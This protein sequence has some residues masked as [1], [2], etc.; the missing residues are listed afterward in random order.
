MGEMQA[1]AYSKHVFNVSSFIPLFFFPLFS[2]L[3]GPAV[4]GG[5]FPIDHPAAV[6]SSGVMY[7]IKTE[8]RAIK[9][10]FSVVEDLQ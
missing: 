2:R 9:I 10:I 3:R 6:S 5:M 4:V 7:E 8:R 1:S